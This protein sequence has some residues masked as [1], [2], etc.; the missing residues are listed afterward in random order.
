MPIHNATLMP[1]ATLKP[2]IM[3]PI[4]FMPCLNVGSLWLV[5]RCKCKND[6]LLITGIENRHSELWE[7]LAIDAGEQ[8]DPF[9]S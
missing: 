1:T 6:A 9:N 8:A 7:W 3:K 4:D 2:R 5:R